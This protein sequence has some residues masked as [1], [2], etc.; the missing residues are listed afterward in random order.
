MMRRRWRLLVLL[1]VVA[2]PV[3]MASSVEAQKVSRNVRVIAHLPAEGGTDLDFDEGR[4]YVSNWSDGLGVTV[5]AVDISGR[6]PRMLGEVECGLG[7]GDVA[8]LGSGIIAIGNHEGVCGAQ[9]AS[10]INLFDMSDPKAPRQLGFWP[11]A[12]GTHTLTKHP[13]EPLI[14]TSDSGYLVDTRTHIIDVSD[15]GAP[16]QVA[17][18]GSSCHDISFR[19][20]KTEKLAFCAVGG[21]LATGGAVEIWDVENPLRPQ[22]VG[23]VVD[24]GLAYPHSAVATPDGKYLVVGDEAVPSSCAQPSAERDYGAIS[25][26]DI[27]DRTSPKLVGYINVP[28]GTARCWAHNFN[29][30]PGTR[31]LVNSWY[32]GGMAVYD[33]SDPRHPSEI[34]HFRPDDRS[35][36]SAYWYRGR[37]YTNGFTGTYV[38]ELKV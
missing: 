15:P 34:A 30:I 5:D 33:L 12:N 1:A 16:R 9:P 36:W 26:Y 4:A 7:Q 35:M 20:T 13:T 11:V 25:I 24:P 38:L 10:G 2:A 14:Y 8:A 18:E 3:A 31:L 37:I 22:V 29:F 17:V 19:I 23:R 28:R 27:R 6:R 32:D 21:T